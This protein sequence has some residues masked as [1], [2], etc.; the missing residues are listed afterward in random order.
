[1]GGTYSSLMIVDFDSSTGEYYFYVK[2]GLAVDSANNV[3]KMDYNLATGTLFFS[4]AMNC[5][6]SISL[7]S[8]TVTPIDCVG[9]VLETKGIAI[10]GESLPPVLRHPF[11]W[12][13]LTHL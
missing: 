1:M 13:K 2:R 4:D 3:C 12:Q 10:G 7:D 9:N 5:V 8:E 6:Y 11:L